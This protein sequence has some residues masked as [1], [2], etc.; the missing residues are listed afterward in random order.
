MAVPAIPPGFHTV[1]PHLAVRGALAALEFYKKAF[2][3]EAI[4][5]MPAMEGKVGHAEIKIGDSIIMLADEWPN[6]PL[7]SPA[8]LKG[9]TVSIMLYVADCDAFFNRAVAAGAKVTMPLMDM[10]WGDRYGQVTDPYGHVWAIATHKE[11]VPPAEMAKRAA[12][13]MKNM[14]KH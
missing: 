6:T 5:C 3:A 1:T 11:D 10:F 2:G 12:E 9:T 8:A 14:G 13:A 7:S 4:M